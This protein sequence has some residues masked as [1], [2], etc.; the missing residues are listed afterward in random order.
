MTATLFGVHMAPKSSRI[1]LPCVMFF[2]LSLSG[3]FLY[4]EPVHMKGGEGIL[5]V[6]VYVDEYSC[7]QLKCSGK[8]VSSIFC[9]AVSFGRDVASVMKFRI[10]R[11]TLQ[12]ILPLLQNYYHLWNIDIGTLEGLV[13]KS[14]QLEN[15]SSVTS[16]HSWSGWPGLTD[17][18]VAGFRVW[19]TFRW[20][21]GFSYNISWCLTIWVLA[22]IALCT[23]LISE[24]I[25]ALGLLLLVE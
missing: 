20:M 10:T 14:S 19:T 5:R 16:V 13:P 8:W 21:Y 24:L 3:L 15:A 7:C 22:S 12:G 23:L 11:N 4:I 6:R 1:S 18:R 25:L 9:G 17:D 2:P